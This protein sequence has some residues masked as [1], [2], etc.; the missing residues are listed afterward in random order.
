MVSG[1]IRRILK[2]KGRVYIMDVT[3]TREM[4]AMFSMAGLKHV[5]S[6][7]IWYPLKVHAAEK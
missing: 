6:K 2:D 7:W 3:S 4:A 5:E 1:E